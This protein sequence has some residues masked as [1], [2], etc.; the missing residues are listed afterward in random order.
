MSG[1]TRVTRVRSTEHVLLST[2]A[3]RGGVL[4]SGLLLLLATGCAAMK[5]SMDELKG[6]P[7]KLDGSIESTALLLVDAKLVGKNLLGKTKYATTDAWIVELEEGGESIHGSVWSTG[8]LSSSKAAVFHKLRPGK[9]RIHKI[10]S[11]V[12]QSTAELAVPPG[13]EFVIELEAGEAR[14]WGR[15]TFS[16]T[17]RIGSGLAWEID[18]DPEL[19]LEEWKSLKKKYKGSAWAPVI[20]VKIREAMERMA[21]TP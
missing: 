16:D 11:N 8:L 5:E 20:D 10:K 12:G 14:Y 4:V 21:T 2:A 3:R 19:E 1:A 7:K 13:E 18:T 17:K 9:Y 6:A 15:C